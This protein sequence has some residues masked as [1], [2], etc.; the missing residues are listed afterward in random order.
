M[1]NLLS[2][3]VLQPVSLVGKN[4]RGQRLIRYRCSCGKEKVLM[5]YNV[6]SGHTRSCGC[7]QRFLARVQNTTHGEG[8]VYYTSAEYR[9]WRGMKN[10]CLNPN[11]PAYSN[12]GGRGISVCDRWLNSFPNFLADMGRKP[13]PRH[14]ID[15][16]DNDG[17]YEPTNCRWATPLEQNNNRRPARKRSASNGDT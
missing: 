2:F 3:P 16:I 10:R 8:K 12:Y 6:K 7:F 14:S 17:H 11:E 1:T 4:S 15:R 13:S 5:E 9:T